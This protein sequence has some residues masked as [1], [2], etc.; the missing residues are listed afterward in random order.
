MNRDETARIM[1]CPSFSRIRILPGTIRATDNEL[2]DNGHVKFD[3]EL[4]H[5]HLFLSLSLSL[6]FLLPFSKNVEWKR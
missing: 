1:S 6:L 4:V 5:Y 3:N 2:V